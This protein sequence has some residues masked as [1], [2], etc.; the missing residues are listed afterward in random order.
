MQ[1][2]RRG[3][4]R[5]IARVLEITQTA[6]LDNPCAPCNGE[7]LLIDQTVC[8]SCG[9][10]GDTLEHLV[11]KMRYDDHDKVNEI[12]PNLTA[13]FAP[14]D[15]ATGRQLAIA[16]VALEGIDPEA[17][18]AWLLA[19][20]SVVVESSPRVLASEDV[21]EWAMRLAENIEDAKRGVGV[22]MPLTQT[23]EA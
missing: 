14:G 12:T 13:N 3:F 15:T 2:E 6:G 23:G 17:L 4:Y 8:E 10:W 7:G 22:L 16:T 9:G 19:N 18:I 11:R 20:A 5:A 21:I 1:A